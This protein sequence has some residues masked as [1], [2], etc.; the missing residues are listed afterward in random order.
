[1]NLDKWI[2]ETIDFPQKIWGRSGF[3]VNLPSNPVFLT[4][5]PVLAIGFALQ[6]EPFVAPVP[7]RQQVIW[8]T[9]SRCRPSKTCPAK[10]PTRNASDFRYIQ[11]CPDVSRD[12]QRCPDSLGFIRIHWDSLGFIGIHWVCWP[13]NTYHRSSSPS[14]LRGTRPS[15]AK[16][17]WRGRRPV[18]SVWY[19]GS[20]VIEIPQ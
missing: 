17:F 7:H 5:K 4:L 18:G 9:T 15:A 14:S 12:V 20:E 6:Q 19:G 10:N 13:T 3:P 1:M 11:M 8:S 16:W 2:Q